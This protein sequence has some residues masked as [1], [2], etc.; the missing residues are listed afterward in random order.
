MKCVDF[1]GAASGTML[2]RKIQITEFAN[3][4]RPGAYTILKMHHQILQIFLSRTRKTWRTFGR[5]FALPKVFSSI[6]TSKISLPREFDTF[7]NVMA[8]FFYN[9]S[10]N[11]TARIAGITTRGMRFHFGLKKVF[12]LRQHIAS[13]RE[14]TYFSDAVQVDT[15]CE[16]CVCLETSWIWTVAQAKHC[17]HS[18]SCQNWDARFFNLTSFVSKHL[19][20]QPV[21]K[22]RNVYIP[23]VV[24]I[25]WGA[26][27]FLFLNTT[28]F[29]FSPF[30]FFLNVDLTSLSDSA[31]INDKQKAKQYRWRCFSHS[32]MTDMLAAKDCGD[33]MRLNTASHRHAEV[34]SLFSTAW[35]RHLLPCTDFQCHRSFHH[36]Q[37][38]S[39]PSYR[40]RRLQSC[41]LAIPDP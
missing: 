15:H 33:R 8:D 13:F 31:S 10:L 25:E 11:L 24:E 6:W 21:C 29:S 1:R 3:Y 39:G 23:T 37:Y 9:S 4:L 28:L 27:R 16:T 35:H 41:N 32:S 34:C 36:C 14:H 22:W 19:E 30:S 17:I 18:N 38:Q 5:H 2:F 26:S 40:S 7:W 12:S 20:F